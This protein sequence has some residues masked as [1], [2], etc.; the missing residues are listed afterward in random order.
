MTTLMSA[1]M[2]ADDVSVAGAD[3]RNPTESYFWSH[4]PAAPVLRRDDGHRLLRP[5][6]RSSASSITA[7]TTTTSAGHWRN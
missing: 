4:N 6:R 2:L 1:F 7:T 5:I 3:G